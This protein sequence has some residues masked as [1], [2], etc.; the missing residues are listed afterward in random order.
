[1]ADSRSKTKG[2]KAPRGKK[3]RDIEN[4]NLAQAWKWATTKIKDYDTQEFWEAVLETFGGNMREAEP[5]YK[6]ERGWKAIKSQFNKIQADC[7]HFAGIAQFF[8]Q[9][10]PTGTN[11]AK[12]FELSVTTYNKTRGTSKKSGKQKDF[13]FANAYNA[14]KD[15]EKFKQLVA[16]HIALS[17]RPAAPTTAAVA[18][19][20]SKPKQ[21]VVVKTED[22]WENTSFGISAVHSDSF[23]QFRKKRNFLFH[24]LFLFFIPLSKARSSPA[25]G[26]GNGA[27][28]SSSVIVIPD[29]P[30]QVEGSESLVPLPPTARDPMRENLQQGGIKTQRQN[31][32]IAAA[33]TTIDTNAAKRR[34]SEDQKFDEYMAN[35]KRHQEETA[36]FQKGMLLLVEEESRRSQQTEEDKLMQMD[37][38]TIQDSKRRRYFEMRQEEILKRFMLQKEKEG[39]IEDQGAA[40]SMPANGD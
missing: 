6:L 34:E 15:C 2:S 39:E 38:D 37:T 23:F 20:P 17:Q 10:P 33:L 9:E 24:Y 18:S 30:V 16:Q 5:E 36:K 22:D 29:V 32:Q 25:A 27:C 3:W 35:S 19:T 40:N 26:L 1:M 7:V 8:E 21:T 11:E 28:S 14:M 12:R 4:V 31:K 13:Q